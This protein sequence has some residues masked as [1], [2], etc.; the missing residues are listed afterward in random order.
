MPLHLEPLASFYLKICGSSQL[1]SG[2]EAEVYANICFIISITIMRILTYNNVKFNIASFRSVLYKEIVS[3][4]KLC[5]I[6]EV[7]IYLFSLLN[8]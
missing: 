3:Y 4:A 2:V 5:L 6:P 7:L 8:K 1:K